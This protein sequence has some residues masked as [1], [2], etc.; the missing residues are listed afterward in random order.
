MLPGRQPSERDQ[1]M[2]LTFLAPALLLI[3]VF[4]YWPL[5]YTFVL[6]FHQWNLTSSEMRFVGLTNF[7]GLLDSPI[8]DAALK[9]TAIYIV[10]SIPLKVLFPLFIALAIWVVST[11]RGIVYKSA[12]F[13]PT[14][15]S[16]VVVS[17]LWMWLLNPL[18]GIGNSVMAML[19]LRLPP[20]LSSPDTALWTILAISAWKIMGFNMLLYLAGLA[21]V[22]R[23]QIEAMRLD[24][25]GDVALFRYLIWPTLSPTTFFVLIVTVIFSIQQVFTPIDILTH[26]GPSNSTTNLFYMV[27]QYAFQSFNIGYGA[28]GTVLIFAI[29]FVV[30]AVKMR[31]LE[32]RVHYQ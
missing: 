14:L 32:S 15:M 13:L 31:I 25:A 3:A 23:D 20:L 10:G 19:G 16:F 28:A 29:I 24:G 26:G 4:I 11:R 27:Y 1:T 9:N 30:T 17:L 22:N 5:I 7:S 2:R 21:S 12:I 18:V 6:A 8:F